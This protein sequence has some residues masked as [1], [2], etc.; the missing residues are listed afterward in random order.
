M[1]HHEWKLI[2]WQWRF[3]ACNKNGSVFLY[4]HKPYK[5]VGDGKWMIR[6]GRA[7]NIGVDPTLAELW[8]QSLS[9]RAAAWYAEQKGNQK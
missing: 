1:K 5:S 9:S 6:K 7:L 3:C 2:E 8:E 4:Q